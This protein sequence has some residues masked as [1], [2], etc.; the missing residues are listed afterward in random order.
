[1]PKPQSPTLTAPASIPV[2]STVTVTG[3]GFSPD[4]LVLL[5][6]SHAGQYINADDAGGF[7]HDMGYTYTGP[8]NAGVDAFVQR[9]RDWVWVSS[10]KFTVG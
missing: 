9:R 2:G 7:T 8:G 10:A 6:D 5:G 3:V 4:E 1:M